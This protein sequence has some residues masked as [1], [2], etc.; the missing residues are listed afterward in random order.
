MASVMGWCNGMARSVI[1]AVRLGGR[2]ELEADIVPMTTLGRS[3]KL[4]GMKPTIFRLA[5]IDD[6]SLVSEISRRAY[7]PVY[8]AIIGAVPKPAWEDYSARIK[9]SRVWIAEVGNEPAGVLVVDRA[10]DFLMIY[11]IAVDPRHQGKGLGAELLRYAESVAECEGVCELRLYINSRME[12]NLSIY[13]KAG[14]V[15]LG[16][17]P[18]PSRSGEFLT[19]MSKRIDSTAVQ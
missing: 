6:A 8:E 3:H 5:K 17:R 14:F 10:L 18:H 16:Q 2:Y 7:S 15:E 4:S 11:S 1:T 9:A 13:R 19:D 12:R